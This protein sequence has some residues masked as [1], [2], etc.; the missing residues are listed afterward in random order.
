MFDLYYTFAVFKINEQNQLNWP[1]AIFKHFFFLSDFFFFLLSHVSPA[2]EAEEPEGGEGRDPGERRRLPEEGEGPPGREEGVSRG[3]GARRRPP[4]QL[5]RRQEVL[6]AAGQ[7]VHRL[8]EPGAG[9][10]QRAAGLAEALGASD[11]GGRPRWRPRRTLPSA[12]RLAGFRNQADALLRISP[13][14]G[15]ATLA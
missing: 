7:P 3:A 12:S 9:G 14:P 13:R 1:A 6:P 8:Q 4:S 11:G 10:G 15:L 5:P 2:A